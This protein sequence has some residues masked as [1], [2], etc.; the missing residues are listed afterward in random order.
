MPRISG[1]GLCRVGGH[2]VGRTGRPRPGLRGRRGRRGGERCRYGGE[3]GSWTTLRTALGSLQR[4]VQRD[5]EGT[6]VGI[7]ACRI[8]GQR[9]VEHRVE[10]G[11]IRPHRTDAGYGRGGVRHHHRRRGIARERGGAGDQLVG[12]AGQCVL[13]RTRPGRLARDHLGSQIRH[14]PDDHVGRGHRGGVGDQLGDAEVED[15]HVVELPGV[16]VAGDDDVGRLDV[17]VDDVLAVRVVEGVGDLTG[18]CPD[19]GEGEPLGGQIATVDVRHREPRRTVDDAVTVDGD[20]VGVVEGGGGLGLR[21][22][23]PLEFGVAA[24][25][26]HLHRLAAAQVRVF[27][28]VHL[29]H[30][31]LAEL[32]QDGV[33][34]EL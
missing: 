1:I 9:G 14:R 13:I 25:G 31:T 27:D 10:C 11:E 15:H 12:G 30:A 16:R 22:E 33:P 20:D 23:A 3:S 26:D 6:A 18:H 19:L 21:G 5:G 29:P 24:D 2:R 4:P 34:G 28:H 7:A 17:A 32:G 8:L